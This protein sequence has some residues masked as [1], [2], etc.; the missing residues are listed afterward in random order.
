MLSQTEYQYIHD[1]VLQ[2]YN[3]DYQY[4]VCITNNPVGSN[5]ANIYDVECYFSQNDINIQSNRFTLQNG[6]KMSLDSNAY[7]TSNTIDKLKRENVSSQTVTVSTKEY[8]YSNV[9]EYPN[10]IVDYETS[11]NHHLS[12]NYA[13]LIPCILMLQVLIGLIRTM[14]KHRG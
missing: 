4:Y 2:M 6:I 5:N 1:L 7:S 11:L 14:F 8:V 10:L 12:I 13:Y 3:Q 9:G